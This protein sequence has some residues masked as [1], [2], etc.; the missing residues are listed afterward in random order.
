M[1]PRFIWPAV[2]LAGVGLVV[3]GVMAIARVPV[4]TIV[5]VVSLMV[6][7]VLAAFVAGQLADVKSATTQVANNTNGLNTRL[8]DIIDAQSHLLH[9][10]TPPAAPDGQGELPDQRAA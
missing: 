10:A 8:L 1:N 3:T 9:L 5:V 2:V 7:P 4:D 6:T